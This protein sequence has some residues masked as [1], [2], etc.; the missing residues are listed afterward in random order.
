[1]NIF[2][3]LFNMAKK[4]LKMGFWGGL[5]RSGTGISST[6]FFLIC[7][8]IMSAILLIVVPFSIIWEEIHNNSVISDLGGWA[9]Y[10][11]A[12]AGLL[13]AAGVT[14]SWSNYSNMKFGGPCGGYNNGYNNGYNPYNNDPYNNSFN[15]GSFNNNS[16]NNNNN[17][18]NNP[19]PNKPINSDPDDYI[20]ENI[21][22]F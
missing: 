5:V 16:F 6:N 21:T 15:N 12:I 8:T 18:Y 22:E 17:T 9:A 20:P 13:G 14:K 2:K 10:I 19:Y 1:M 7:T 11:G 3:K 4:K